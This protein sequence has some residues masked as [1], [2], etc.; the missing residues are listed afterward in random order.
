MDD[1]DVYLPVGIMVVLLFILS[2]AYGIGPTGVFHSIGAIGQSVFSLALPAQTAGLVPGLLLL[3]IM[4][5]LLLCTDMGF[6][7][8]GLTAIV[9][10][11][12]LLVV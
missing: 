10:V 8:L 11:F 4:A 9:F 1:P 2:E 5:A 7:E 6:S 3:G 12:I